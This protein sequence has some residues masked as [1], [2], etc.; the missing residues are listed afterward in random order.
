[1]TT[2]KDININDS[3]F[4]GMVFPLHFM[5]VWLA[6]RR[7]IIFPC[8]SHSSCEIHDYFDFR[9]SLTSIPAS[10]KMARKVPSAISLE[11][12]GIVTFRP[13]I[14]CRHN[15]WLPGPCRSKIKIELTQAAYNF[16]VFE[17]RQSS[18]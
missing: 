13:S 3:V 4:K 9:N 11:C 2:N 18:H 16:V 15:S 17:T 14:L 12:L 10:R 6:V 1:M 5:T 7:N 8:C